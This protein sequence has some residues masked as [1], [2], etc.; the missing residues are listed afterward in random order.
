M[1][2]I[3]KETLEADLELCQLVLNCFGAYVSIKDCNKKYVYANRK[4]IGLPHT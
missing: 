1:I 2:T 4:I 3:E